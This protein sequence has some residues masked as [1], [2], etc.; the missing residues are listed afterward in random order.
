MNIY[1][2]ESGSIN[3]HSKH[4]R[5]FVIALVHIINKKKVER[6]YKR[7][8][9]SNIERLKELDKVKI[10][11]SG[12]IL[13][14]GGK[15]FES[16]KFRELKGAQ[17]DR[18]MKEKFVEC[19]TN[20]GGFEIYYIRLNNPKLTDGLCSDIATAFNYPLKMALEYFINKG[21][22]PKE[23]CHLQLDERNEKTNKKYF[24]EQYINTEFIARGITNQKVHV[25]YFD[26]SANKMIQIADV[27]ANL[28]YSHLITN[29]YTKELDMLKKA[30][31]L[32]FVFKFP[33][34]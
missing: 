3:N 21:Y 34:S 20:C 8:V 24:L 18:E 19:F 1:I 13:R 31:I 11:P 29:K 5:Y 32:K 15:M 23:E 22:L 6:T 27:F 26:S 9:A 14:E 33:L 7:F 28:Y 30:G 17:F 2:D 16:G 4:E 25:T 10:N 12:V